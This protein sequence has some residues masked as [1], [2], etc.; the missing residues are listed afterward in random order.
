MV[1]GEPGGRETVRWGGGPGEVEKEGKSKKVGEGSREGLGPVPV[2][3]IPPRGSGGLE[4]D[5]TAWGPG[6]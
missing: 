2:C 1:T 4:S 6:I 5:P 3:L